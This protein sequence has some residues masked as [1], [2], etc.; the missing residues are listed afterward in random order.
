MRI[1]ISIDSVDMEIGDDVL[2]EDAYLN[3]I[4]AA[5]NESFPGAV[6]TCLQVGY[7]QGDAW[8]QI[9]GKHSDELLSVIQ[10]IDTSDESLY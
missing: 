9:N 6:I 1:S 5:V 4:R 8:T 2:D 7:R 3:R 10:R